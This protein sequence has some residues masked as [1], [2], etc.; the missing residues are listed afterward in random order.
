MGASYL[1]A[2]LL[3]PLG[4]AVT[5]EVHRRGDVAAV[6]LADQAQ[7]D[8]LGQVDARHVAEPLVEGL[9]RL[10]ATGIGAGRDTAVSQPRS[11]QWKSG[12]EYSRSHEN[13]SSVSA[14]VSAGG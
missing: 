13:M 7:V 2:E 6:L 3:D 11:I 9:A 8:H 12:P 10:D 14:V 4:K 1:A 5:G